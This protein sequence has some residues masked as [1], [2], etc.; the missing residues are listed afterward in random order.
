MALD[1]PITVQSVNG[2]DRNGDSWLQDYAVCI[3]DQRGGTV[4]LYV[5]QWIFSGRWRSVVRIDSAVLSN[6][7]LTGNIAQLWRWWGVWRHIVQL[8]ADGQHAS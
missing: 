8:H 6:C 5:D 3:Y 2:P 1:K 7:V 4:G